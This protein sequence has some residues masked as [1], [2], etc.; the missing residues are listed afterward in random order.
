MIR[1]SRL[2]FGRKPDSA[3]F[4]GMSL[5]TRSVVMSGKSPCI[6]PPIVERRSSSSRYQRPPAVIVKLSVK[7]KFISPKTAVVSS[8]ES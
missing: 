6:R 8:E 3:D 7:S 4:A 5:S 2:A 1:Y